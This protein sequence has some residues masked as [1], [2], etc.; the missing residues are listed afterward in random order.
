MI[1]ELRGVDGRDWSVWLLSH[2]LRSE[3]L[4]R[5]SAPAPGDL[6]AVFYE[7]RRRREGARPGENADYEAFRVV[8]ER[9]EVTAGDAVDDGVPF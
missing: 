9:A 3:F 8:V 7:G 2:V 5:S 1:A 6:V 4:E